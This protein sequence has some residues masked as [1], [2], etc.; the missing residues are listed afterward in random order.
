MTTNTLPRK[1]PEQM[2]MTTSSIL[3]FIKAVESEQLEL[4]SLMIVKNDHVITEGWWEPYQAED[5]H[6][7]NSL[8][9]SFTSSAIG[10]AVDEQLMSVE[11]P[12]LKFFPEYVTPDIEANMKNLLVKHL[13]SMSTG[14][15]QDTLPILWSN[16]TD[17]VKAFLETPINREPGTY[18]LYNT[19]ASYML[20][21]IIERVTG[22]KLLDYLRPRLLDPL[23]IEDV[24]TLTCPQ[25]VH[26]GGYG[27]KIRTEDI[28]KFG[29]LYLHNG[30]WNGQRILSEEWVQAATAKQVSNGEPGDP[31]DW[32]QGYGYQFWRCRHDVYRG[33][34]AFGQ[35]C[36][37][38]PAHNAV[39]AITSGLMEMQSVLDLVWEHLL[40][41]MVNHPLEPDTVGQ[42]EL[43]QKLNQLSYFP[44]QE[45]GR[46]PV[47]WREGGKTYNLD[48][49]KP[50]YTKVSFKE[51][52]D[53]VQVT[54][55]DNDTTY[56]IRAGLGRFSRGNSEID[57]FPFQ[58]AACGVWKK[59][60]V[61]EIR[62]FMT[63]YALNDRIICHFVN[64]SVRITTAR[65]VWVAPVLSDMGVLPTL[66]GSRFKERDTWIGVTNKAE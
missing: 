57:G 56:E 8:S 51:D 13:L 63:E 47:E 48:K 52:H 5:Q 35:F 46:S 37:V 7:L 40:P 15:T 65:N 28:A 6:Q 44:I 21:A 24:T 38:M 30:M 58:Y 2:G 39:I 53:E 25:G 34:G 9:K 43:S 61:L 20:S 4:H 64:D 19:G 60:N 59:K 12:V 54:F 45:P 33:D 62:L 31:S 23:G 18:F 22:Q 14:H 3:S 32:S 50:G 16:S 11:D 17:W 10:L 26:A 49:N 29:L 55:A 27:M 41:G 36:I 1:T 66:V 42:T